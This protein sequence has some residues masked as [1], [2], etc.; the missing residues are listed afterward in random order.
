MVVNTILTIAVGSIS[1][2]TTQYQD[3]TTSKIAT[4]FGVSLGPG[5]EGKWDVFDSHIN[6]ILVSVTFQSYPPQGSYGNNL[7]SFPLIHVW[8]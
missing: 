2:V 5:F 7:K 6:S 4:F 8:N 3:V 1:I